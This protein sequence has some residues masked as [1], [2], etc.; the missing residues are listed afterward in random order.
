MVALELG[1]CSGVRSSRIWDI[2]EAEPRVTGFTD[3]GWHLQSRPVVI[4]SL[5]CPFQ[6]HLHFIPSLL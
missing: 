3:E 1:D 6:M 2:L 5:L 4:H